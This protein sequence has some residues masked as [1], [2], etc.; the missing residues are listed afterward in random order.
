VNGKAENRGNFYYINNELTIAL[1]KIDLETASKII[2]LQM[3]DV[4]VELRVV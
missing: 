3:R 1:T 2:A 4:W